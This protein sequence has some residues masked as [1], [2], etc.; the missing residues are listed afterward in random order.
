MGIL[1]RHIFAKN[2]RAYTIISA[3]LLGTAVIIGG[4]VFIASRSKVTVIADESYLDEFEVID[5]EVHI[6]CIVSLR[7]RSGDDKTVRI[8]GDFQEE[9]DMGLLKENHLEAFF[10]EDGSNTIIIKGNSTIRN[11]MIEFVGEY[12]GNAVMSS[13]LLPQMKVIEVEEK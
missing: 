13:R 1:L 9:V 4:C 5:Q 6:Y 11:I 10:V 8:L 12:G 3:I 2:K 7:N